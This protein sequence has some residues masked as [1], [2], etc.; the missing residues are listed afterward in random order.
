MI[1]LVKKGRLM[2][3]MIHLNISPNCNEYFRPGK[4]AKEYF[5]PGKDILFHFFL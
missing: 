2:Y 1:N 4:D 3:R 5:R